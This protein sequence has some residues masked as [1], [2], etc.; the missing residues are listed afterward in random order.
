MTRNEVK[1]Y[2]LKINQLDNT[3][4][5]SLIVSKWFAIKEKALYLSLNKL[6]FGDMLLVGLF[7]T[8]NSQILRIN[9]RVQYMKMYRIV[10]GPLI[11]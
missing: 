7:W 1:S 10:V 5:S 3:D 8:P 9:E 6:K 11:W 4:I 2:L